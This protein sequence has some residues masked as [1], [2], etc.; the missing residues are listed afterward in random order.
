MSPSRQDDYLLRQLRTV[1][2]MLAGVAGLRVA[3]QHEE[4]RVEL[5]QSY[6]LLL[7]PQALLVR[8]LDA[9]TAAACLDSPEKIVAYA[10]LV[11]EEAAQEPDV[12][13]RAVLRARAVALAAEAARQ[14]PRDE[15]IARVVRELS[16]RGE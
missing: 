2:Q 10:L 15:D 3:G 8:Q 7:G 9:G 12:G 5:E 14:D 6:G 16:L 1:A 13:R 11:D 4:A